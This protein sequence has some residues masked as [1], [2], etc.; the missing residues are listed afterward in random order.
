MDMFNR[1][2]LFITDAFNATYNQ[3][4]RKNR[5]G[6]LLSMSL[7]SL[8]KENIHLDFLISLIEILFFIT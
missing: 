3:E 1:P 4:R 7:L 2:S 8:H 6:Q 5:D